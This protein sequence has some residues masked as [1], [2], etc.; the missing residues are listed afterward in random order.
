MVDLPHPAIGEKVEEAVD[1]LGDHGA[2]VFSTIKDALTWAY[3]G[4]VDVLSWPH[5]MVFAA[6]VALVAW[7]VRSHWFALF[8]AGGLILIDAL[9]LW[10]PAIETL[11]LVLISALLAVLI[12]IPVGIVAA[13]HRRVRTVTMPALD[14]MQTMPA[15]V[16]LIP[17]VSFFRIGAVPGIVATVVFSMPPAVRLTV[18]GIGQVDPE[19]V[20]A[21]QA[22]GASPWQILW[23]VQLPLAKA[24]IM[25]GVNQVIM[26]ALSMVVIAGMIAAG[27]LGSIVYRGVTR[28]QIGVAFEAGLAV[29]ILAVILDRFTA[30]FAEPLS[31][32]RRRP[33]RTAAQDP[34]IPTTTTP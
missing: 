25:A 9:E 33:R 27:G 2:S 30:A 1:W 23:S 32:R 18:L 34:P 31:G 17:V 28:L 16:Y 20:E 11:S 10:E 26:L 12:G 14:V 4:L 6:L 19:V 13:R 15:F 8:A 22:F 7:R 3:D 24:T 29:V 5:P 21:G